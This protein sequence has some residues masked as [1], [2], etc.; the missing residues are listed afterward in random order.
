MVKPM[1]RPCLNTNAG[2]PSGTTNVSSVHG[3]ETS[4]QVFDMMWNARRVNP[5]RF[6]PAGVA[7]VVHIRPEVVSYSFPLDPLVHQPT[8]VADLTLLGVGSAL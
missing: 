8:G 7:D 6:Q 3:A 2:E 5:R 4:R 1:P